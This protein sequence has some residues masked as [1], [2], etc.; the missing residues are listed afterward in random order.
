MIREAAHGCSGL[1]RSGYWAE[2]KWVLG[3]SEKGGGA[4]SQRTQEEKQHLTLGRGLSNSRVRKWNNTSEEGW[5]E[6]VAASQGLM[7]DEEGEWQ[8]PRWE[9]QSH[10]DLDFSFSPKDFST[11]Y[12]VKRRRLESHLCGRIS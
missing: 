3:N 1:R 4:K 2:E 9:C 8:G 7:G 12:L 5:T 10:D 11:N 6:Q